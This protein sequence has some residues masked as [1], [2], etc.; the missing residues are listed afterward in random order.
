MIVRINI[1]K[2]LNFVLDK[3]CLVNNGSISNDNKNMFM[4]TI[5]QG[6]RSPPPIPNSNAVKNEKSMFTIQ[7]NATIS[8]KTQA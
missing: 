6:L 1:G 7:F 2:E 4:S 3:R 5:A 8:K